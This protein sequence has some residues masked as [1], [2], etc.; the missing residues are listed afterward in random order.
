MLREEGLSRE[1]ARRSCSQYSTLYVTTISVSL[2]CVLSVV[3]GQHCLG[4]PYAGYE[5]AWFLL[6]LRDVDGVAVSS[7]EGPFCHLFG[8][9]VGRAERGLVRALLCAS[10]GG[11][12]LEVSGVLIVSRRCSQIPVVAG[13]QAVG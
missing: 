13:V 2:G 9:T 7:V 8:S 6:H 4:F 5:V 12:S 11:S 3:F 10:D 1:V